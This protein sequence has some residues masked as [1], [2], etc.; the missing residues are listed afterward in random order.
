MA[1]FNIQE[2]TNTNG[3]VIDTRELPAIGVDQNRGKFLAVGDDDSVEWKEVQSGIEYSAGDGIGIQ[4]GI[5]S[6]T[7]DYQD[8]SAMSAYY[9]K[10]ATSAASEIDTEFQNTS[11]WAQDTFAEKFTPEQDNVLLVGS[12]DGGY[13]WQE[14]K[15]SAFNDSTAGQEIELWGEFSGTRFYAERASKDE[16]GN[17]IAGT[18]A[19]K[20]ES[21][22]RYVQVADW[23]SADK[24]IPEVVTDVII[25]GRK[26]LTVII[27]NQE[28]LAENLDFKY[29]G[30]AIGGAASSSAPVA[31]YY[32]N[33]EAT[34][35]VDGNKYGL[36]YNE[37]AAKLLDDN[38]A[39]I[40]PRGWRVPTLSDY[41]TLISYCGSNRN[42]YAS[43]T[44][45][46]NRNGTND[47]G[48]DAYPTGTRNTSGQFTSVGKE[49]LFWTT[50]VSEDPSYARAFYVEEFMAMAANYPINA[51]GA[52]RLVKDLV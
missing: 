35:G 10:S 29:P 27:G 21:D 37:P 34:Y 8:V 13:G 50:T 19:T 40:F 28:W 18:Y 7:G 2:F 5:I 39:T 3:D 31:N 25:G 47:S 32:N 17:N 9:E 52:I 36:L 43:I 14:L 45:W 41:D 33:D 6:V 11:A 15:T 42:V 49:T 1:E 30:I 16:D 24:E 20:A 44:G 48:F 46:T 23:A 51:Q 4:S 22:S 26:Y 12:A 38:K